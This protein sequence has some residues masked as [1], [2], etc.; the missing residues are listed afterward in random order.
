MS[1]FWFTCILMLLLKIPDKELVYKCV[2]FIFVPKLGDV[3]QALEL[4]NEL[5]KLGEEAVTMHFVVKQNSELSLPS[6]L[7]L[8]HALPRAGM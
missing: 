6:V 4:T 3:N 1:L 2:I 7:S 5:L 8:C